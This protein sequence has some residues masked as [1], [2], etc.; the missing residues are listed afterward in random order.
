MTCCR[1][2]I[3]TNWGIL[4]G[5]LIWA[6]GSSSSAWAQA[7]ATL[8]WSGI[9]WSVKSGVGLGPGVN[10]WSPSNVSIDGNGDLHLS[11]TNVGGTWYC[12]EIGST[13]TFGFGTF[14]WQLATAVDNLDANVVL[15]LFV[16]GPTALGPDGTHEIDVEYA[17]FGS[18]TADNGWWTIFPNVITHAAGARSIVV[19]ASARRGPDHDL[20][21]RMGLDQ[22]R[23]HD[24][25]WLPT[26]R[27]EQ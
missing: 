11:I 17:R 12:A 25:G 8:T 14:Q 13:D 19:P 18:A 9:Q 2:R 26:G 4:L 22:R 10:S 5:A 7:P 27:L 3:R 6:A 24:L 20:A 15:G 1:K 16:Y 23:V 21:L